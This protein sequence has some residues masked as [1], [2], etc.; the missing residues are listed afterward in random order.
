MISTSTEKDHLP[1]YEDLVRERGDAVAEAQLAADHTQHQA[2]ELLTG[3]D[4][5]QQAHRR[6][7][8]TTAAAGGQPQWGGSRP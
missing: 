5:A 1:I 4:A 2:A 6:D 8:N 7:D 3:R